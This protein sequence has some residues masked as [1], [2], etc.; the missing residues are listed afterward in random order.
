MEAQREEGRGRRRGPRGHIQLEEGWELKVSSQ[1]GKRGRKKNRVK[2][3]RHAMS[4]ARDS[5]ERV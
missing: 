5:R 1:K 3:E 4:R 2:Q